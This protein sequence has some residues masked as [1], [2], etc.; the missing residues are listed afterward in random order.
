M[1]PITAILGFL[2]K[3]LCCLPDVVRRETP[4]TN[5]IDPILR[6]VDPADNLRQ[7]FVA[8]DFALPK[9]WAAKFAELRDFLPN[10]LLTEFSR[11]GNLNLAVLAGKPVDEARKT[12]A[13]SNVAV[14]EHEVTSEADIPVGRTLAASSFAAP[15]ESVVMY[16]KGNQVL[17]F[18]RYAETDALRLELAALR[19]EVER[20]KSGSP[21]GQDSKP[22]QPRRKK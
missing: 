3:T 8:G 16:K 21:A 6:M 12:L 22:D 11:A 18:G 13:A 15:G 4:G 17:A 14:V 10:S 19:Q 20:L 5:A 2:V 7:A 9:S 1:I